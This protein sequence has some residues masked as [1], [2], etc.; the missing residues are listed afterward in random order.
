MRRY[1]MLN[2]YIAII[3]MQIQ[4]NYVIKL[5]FMCLL[6]LSCDPTVCYVGCIKVLCS[7][8]P[9]LSTFWNI[10]QCANSYFTYTYT[11]LPFA[12]FAYSSTLY[13]LLDCRSRYCCTTY[14]IYGLYILK[15]TWCM[16]N[17]RKIHPP[18]SNIMVFFYKRFT[19]L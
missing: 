5:Q 14:K 16:K 4:S 15:C 17:L 11:S 7:S 1:I 9:L 12:N 6:C 8:L 3:I 10:W 18:T 2:I 19:S 13:L